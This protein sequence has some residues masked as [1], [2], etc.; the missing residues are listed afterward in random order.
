MSNGPVCSQ[1]GEA[2]QP[3]WHI[4]P[5]C[6]HKQARAL[7]QIRCRVCSRRARVSLKICPHCGADLE[8][9]PFPVLPVSFATIIIVVL[10]YGIGQWGSTLL[11][12]AEQVALLI[13]P[14][15][16][17]STPTTT[18]TFTPTSTAT[19]TSTPTETATPT[20]TFTFT[21][22]PPT[23]TAT[24]TET[25][26]EAPPGV[27]TATDTPTITPTPTPKYGKPQLLGPED[28]TIFGREQQLMLQWEN[29]GP[30]APNEFYA[31]RLTWQQDGQLAYGGTNIK[32]NFWI[33]PPDAYWSL[34]D[35]FT[36]RKYEWYV[37]IE[38]ITTD[39]A[40]QQ[41][42]KPVSEVSDTLSFLWQ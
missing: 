42:G 32:E 9:K 37:Y 22:I 4:C 8:A 6:G 41:V 34:A 39:E 31:V 10:T 28:G 26:T 15:T 18:P 40:G 19:P 16:A 14:P 29:M 7:R 24:P 2:I 23:T 11:N 30:L 5:N 21:P 33:I 20:P 38:E 12:D 17:T 27:P 25:P 36:G 13:N 3:G 35:E 1:C